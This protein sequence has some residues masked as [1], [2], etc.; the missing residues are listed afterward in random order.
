MKFGIIVS[1]FNNFVTEKL[2]ES[3]LDGLKSHG[4]EEN[5]IDIVH[6]PGAF[7][8]PLLA[9]KMAGSGRYDALICLGAV[10]RGETP[11][12]DYIAAEVSRGIADAMSQ[13]RIPIAF[14]VLTTNNVEQ[15]MER[16]GLKSENKGFEAA[17]TAI[18]MVNVNREIP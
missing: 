15:A 16:A 14:G 7:E 3:A 1:R 8:I 6:V 9:G 17:L 11:H 5:N 4:G 18:E 12:F 10:I 2:L 13:H